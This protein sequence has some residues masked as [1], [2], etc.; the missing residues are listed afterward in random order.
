MLMM[1]KPS[2]GLSESKK[3]TSKFAG[4]P[5]ITRS[6]DVAAGGAVRVIV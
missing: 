3:W 6:I 1:R 4:L 5:L 2:R